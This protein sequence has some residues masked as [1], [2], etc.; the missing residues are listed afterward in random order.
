MKCRYVCLFRKRLFLK[1]ESLSES[2]EDVSPGMRSLVSEATTKSM[3]YVDALT[4][5]IN[6]PICAQ[7]KDFG[8]SVFLGK[9]MKLLVE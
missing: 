9:L 3:P 2:G 8:W 7:L 5:I 1:K 4:H 6:S